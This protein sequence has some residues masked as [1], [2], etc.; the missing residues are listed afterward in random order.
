MAYL[1]CL[2]RPLWHISEIPALWRLRQEELK[3]KASLDNI[4]KIHE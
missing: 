3:F 4:F 2:I 1:K